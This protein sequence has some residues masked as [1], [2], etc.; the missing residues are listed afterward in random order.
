MRHGDSLVDEFLYLGQIER[1]AL[2]LLGSL[3]K[4]SD[5]VDWMGM[6]VNRGISS[7]RAG[8]DRGVYGLSG[9]SCFFLA[10]ASFSRRSSR[11]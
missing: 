9:W 7:T 2:I 8:E 5:P 1:L 3:P 6:V 4:E 11:T 10:A